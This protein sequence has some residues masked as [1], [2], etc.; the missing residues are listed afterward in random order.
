MKEKAYHWP[1]WFAASLPPSEQR[2]I[3]PG[4]IEKLSRANLCL[5]RALNIY[6]DFLDG[7]GRPETLPA[8]N[9]YYRRYLEIYYR[10]DLSDD[11][12]RLFDRVNADLDAANLREAR[13]PRLLI[14][15]GRVVMPR[16]LPEFKSL[17]DLSDKSLALGLGPLA[18]IASLGG[19]T[20]S[21][22]ANT[23]ARLTKT[24][25]F[26]RYALAAKQF[27]DDARDWREDLKKGA[28]SACNVLILK[29]ARRRHLS[30]DWKRRPIAAYLLFVAVS[31][32]ISSRLTQLCRQTRLAGRQ[33]G[34]KPRSRLLQEIIGPLERGLTESARFRSKLRIS[35]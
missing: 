25:N 3:K 26:F 22:R 10:L 6:D 12:F 17:R 18:I 31:P 28:I 16:R 32:K 8:A 20:T 4:L 9:A 7:E 24:L 15:D 29:E 23:T 27:A 13:C 14:E 30:L 21:A 2:L 19:T 33:A 11:F 5:W 34:L 1:R 35:L